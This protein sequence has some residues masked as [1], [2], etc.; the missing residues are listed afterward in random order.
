MR[1]T[2]REIC[3]KL[4]FEYMFLNEQENIL[5]SEIVLGEEGLNDSDKEFIAT[6][7]NG[8]IENF[9]SLKNEIANLSK[10]FSIE[11]IYRVDLSI[12]LIAIYELDNL[13]DTPKAV[14]IDEAVRIAKVY[15]TENSLNFVNGILAEYV[16]ERS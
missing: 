10:K 9:D 12:L 16:K 13:D 4:I 11:R 2:A 1:K 3:F 15:S 5:E 8:V 14:V 7:Y 6:I